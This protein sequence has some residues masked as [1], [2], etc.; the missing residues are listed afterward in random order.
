MIAIARGLDRV[1]RMLTSAA[2][3]VA[4]IL[5]MLAAIVITA[6]VL[7]VFFLDTPIPVVTEI[8]STTLAIIIFSALAFAQYR[9]QNV[10]I[11]IVLNFLPASLRRILLIFS[12]FV[13]FLLF[14]LLAWRAFTLAAT[15]WASSETAMALIPFPVYPFKIGVAIAATIAAAELLR[16]LVWAVLTG[17]VDG[18]SSPSLGPE[19]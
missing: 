2:I 11:D 13:S 1:I 14:T 18:A 19:V 10:T 7:S 16:E 3:G 8:A 12:S 15:S 6:D 4:A 9:R 5:I 17:D